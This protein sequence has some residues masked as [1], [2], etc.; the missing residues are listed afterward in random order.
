MSSLS[1]PQGQA[2]ILNRLAQLTPDSPR[3]WGRMTVN[4][5]L[6]H[7]ADSYSL[8]LGAKQASRMPVLIPRPLMKWVALNVPMRWPKNLATRPEMAQEFGGTPPVGFEE[9]RRRLVEILKS[10]CESERNF[11]SIEH[12]I[13]LRMKHAEWLR[14]GYLHADHHLRQFGC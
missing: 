11:A 8:A 14:W 2:E 1:L 6:C 5:M 12:P 4:Q 3:R 7:L 10:F 13:F 9:D